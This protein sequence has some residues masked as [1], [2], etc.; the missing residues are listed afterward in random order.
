MSGAGHEKH[1][2]LT[3]ILAFLLSFLV[4]LCLL[5][6]PVGRAMVDRGLWRGAAEIALP[7]QQEEVLRG[8]G[9]V[10]ETLPFRPETA[11]AFY[12]PERVAELSRAGADWLFSLIAGESAPLPDFSAD[13]LVEAILADPLYEAEGPG[14]QRRQIARDEGAYGV[15]RA[16][17]RAVMPLRVSLLATAQRRLPVAKLARYLRIG[18]GVLA[19]AAL[20]T[21]AALLL[22]K[23]KKW[24]GAAL[25]GGAL[26]ALF[27]MAPIMMLDIPGQAA[28]LS[29]VFG[30]QCAAFLRGL[31]GTFLWGVGIAALLGLGL[32]ILPLRKNGRRQDEA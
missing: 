24:L 23:K 3:R 27:L 15:E 9:A 21:A 30:A 16:V 20:L 10:A 31:A 25:S 17:T 11:L 1:R 26:G 4:S 12:P 29:P 7:A 13:D 2:A 19:G 6:V 14:A 32:T 18:A 28:A 22:M 8:V 5:L